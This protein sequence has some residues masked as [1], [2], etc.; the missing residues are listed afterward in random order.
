MNRKE[1]QVEKRHNEKYK[2]HLIFQ[3]YHQTSEKCRRKKKQQEDNN[4]IDGWTT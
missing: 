4:D 2:S 3:A 1:K